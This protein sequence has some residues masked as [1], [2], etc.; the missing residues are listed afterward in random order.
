MDRWA[1]AN[2]GGRLGAWGNSIVFQVV[3]KHGILGSDI[4]AGFTCN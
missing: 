2:D 3:A 1:R 4:H